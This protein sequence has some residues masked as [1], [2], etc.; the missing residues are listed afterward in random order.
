[1]AE[2]IVE[3][4]KQ[5]N[6]ERQN[7]FYQANKAE[8]NAKR[9]EMYKACKKA[10]QVK[11][12]E[13]THELVEVH[14][15]EIV[16]TEPLA[17]S[18]IDYSKKKKLTYEEIRQGLNQLEY[19]SDKTK[20]KYLGDLQ[21]LHKITECPDYMKCFKNPDIILNQ[22][23]NSEYSVNTVK[24]AIQTILFVID[25]LEL[26]NTKKE[27]FVKAFD[28]Y[29][30]KSLDHTAEKQETEKVMPFQNYIDLVKEKYGENS[31]MFMIAMLY[32]ELTLRDDFTLKIVNSGK[33]LSTEFNYIIIPQRKGI[34]LNTK[35]RIVINHYKTS[36][37]YGEINADVSVELSNMIREYAKQ[38]ELKEGDFLFG[39]KELSNYVSSKNKQMGLKGSISLFRQMKISD[40][41]SKETDAKTRVELAEKLKHSPIV[42]LRYLRNHF[43][44]N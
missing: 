2:E 41:L 1:M 10:T 14:L 43:E 40:V 22:L 24:S 8:I 32:D 44:K 36:E 21:R 38:N 39:E 6:R 4:M 27:A 25:K 5:Q 11:V 3:K 34:K 19:K 28:I 33:A 23:D 9:R 37:K 42:Q 30:L 13:P 7:K 29:K 15:D 17:I 16:A 35:L 20:Q 12:K 18:K 26:K 31:K